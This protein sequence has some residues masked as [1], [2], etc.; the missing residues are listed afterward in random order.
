MDKI[1]DRLKLH[2]LKSRM[3]RFIWRATGLI[4]GKNFLDIFMDATG[5]TQGS[6]LIDALPY[7]NEEI[8]Y[9]MECSASIDSAA[10]FSSTVVAVFERLAYLNK[11]DLSDMSPIQPA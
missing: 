6:M 3:P 2:L 10:I 11:L 5:I 8:K 4:G 7:D 9:V 1:P